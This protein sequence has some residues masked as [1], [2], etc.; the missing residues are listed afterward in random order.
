MQLLSAYAI[1]HRLTRSF[2]SSFGSLV[3]S[4]RS[5]HT[6]IRVLSFPRSLALCNVFLLHSVFLL[7]TS[8]SASL[9]IS[10]AFLLAFF[11]FVYVFFSFCN[12]LFS[13]ARRIRNQQIFT[14]IARC[15]TKQP[16]V[17]LIR[18][19]YTHM[20]VCKISTSFEILNCYIFYL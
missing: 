7:S 4:R 10:F 17:V 11:R 9:L 19:S 5:L 2:F 16:L 14:I 12:R 18:H 15:A 3:V 20:F 6:L 8:I 1:M 13:S